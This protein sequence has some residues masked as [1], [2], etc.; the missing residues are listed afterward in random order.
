MACPAFLGAVG[1]YGLG[2]GIIL[3]WS[4]PALIFDFTFTDLTFV[5]LAFIEMV[6]PSVSPGGPEW[7]QLRKDTKVRRRKVGPSVLLSSF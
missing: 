2:G 3:S 6:A 4:P 5:C 1:V 7:A